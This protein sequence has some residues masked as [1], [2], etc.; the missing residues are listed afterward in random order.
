MSEPAPG[1]VIVIS[2]HVIRGSVGNRAAVFALETTGASGL[3][4]ADGYPALASRPWPRD[5]SD[6][7]CRGFRPVDRRSDPRA[8]DGR[9]PCRPFWIPR[10]RPRRPKRVAR[11]VEALRVKN[12]DLFYA[13]DPVMGDAGGLYVPEATAIAMRDRLLP[14]ASLA[15]PNRFE[16]SWLCGVELETNTALLEAALSLGPP[17]MLV[18]SRRSD[19]AGQHRQSLSVRQSCASGRTPADRQSAERYRRSPGCTVCARLLEGLNEEW[20]SQ[21]GNCQ[22]F[23]DHRP[24]RQTRRRRVDARAR[25]LQSCHADGHGSDAAVAAS[26]AEKAALISCGGSCPLPSHALSE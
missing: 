25:C 24:H 4:L 14:L 3:G 21:C 5:A 23:R 18:T 7:W 15:T 13:C 12:P 11:L 16:L 1:A 19:D 20:P 2:S 26:R 22:R 17:R 10:C 8:V 9:S 6:G